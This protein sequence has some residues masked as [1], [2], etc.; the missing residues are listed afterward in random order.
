MAGALGGLQ[1]LDAGRKTVTQA[2]AS[3][4]I[5]VNMASCTEQGNPEDG[6][7]H[8]HGCRQ[9]GLT[10]Q[11]QTFQEGKEPAKHEVEWGFCVGDTAG[12]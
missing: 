4:E 6:A 2:L 3:S 10:G 7:L 11:E 1:E 9:G 5:I 12:R 8:V